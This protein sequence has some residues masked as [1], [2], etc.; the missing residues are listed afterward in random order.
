MTI[1]ASAE[2]AKEK[3]SYKLFEGSDWSTG[4]YFNKKGYLNGLHEEPDDNTVRWAELQEMIKDT[5]IRNAYLMAVAPNSSTS[6]IAGSTASI[7]P[8]FQP[9]YYEEKKDFKIPVTAPDMSPETYNVYRRSA[10]IVDQRWSVKQNAVRQKHID[11]AISFNM[12]VP[13]TIRASVLLDLHLQAWES[14][15]K[16]SY[17]VRST[18]ND[19]EECEWCHS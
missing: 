16:T 14:G 10:Y 13:N 7:D 5:G 18:S 12:Y 2:I 17:Y 15:L 11:Q 4:E 6:I 9:F 1:K 8:I 3:G 19:I